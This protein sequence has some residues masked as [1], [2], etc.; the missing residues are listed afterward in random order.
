MIVLFLPLKLWNV[1]TLNCLPTAASDLIY[2]NYRIMHL[3]YVIM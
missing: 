2:R 1:R 3:E